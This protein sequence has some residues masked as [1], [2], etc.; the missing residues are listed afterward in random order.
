MHDNDI[1]MLM[2]V[3]IRQYR[4][5]PIEWMSLCCEIQEGGMKTMI[6]EGGSN[7]SSVII[8][9]RIVDYG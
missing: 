5:V 6:N 2:R 4:S 1:D 3:L 8:S 9:N 7:F